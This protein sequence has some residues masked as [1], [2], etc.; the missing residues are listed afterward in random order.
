M[1]IINPLVVVF[2]KPFGKTEILIP[3]FT[4]LEEAVRKCPQA[5]VLINFLH[6]GSAYATSREALT[7]TESIT[8]VVV[9]AEGV[10]E[11]YARIFIHGG[12]RKRKWLIGPAT[13]GG[14][15]AGKFKI[16]NAGGTIENIV[17]S[18]P[19]EPVL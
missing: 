7:A 15:A 10:P 8:T 3:L 4:T 6:T 16:G 9:I 17:A 1:A 5:D 2:T 19:T 18:K 13:V 11:R 14:V 12:K